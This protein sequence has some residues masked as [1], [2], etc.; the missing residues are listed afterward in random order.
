MKRIALI[1][2]DGTLP[3][4]ALCKLEKHHKEQGDQVVWNTLN[5][6]LAYVSL[7]FTFNRN[8]LNYWMNKPNV[9]IGGSGYDF[10]EENDKLK[11]I[12]N[13]T[14]P[15]YIEDINIHKNFGF[16]TR[17][18]FRNCPFCI[19]PLKEGKGRIVGDLWCLWDKIS[20]EIRFFDNNIL[21]FPKHFM[22]LCHEL[23]VNCL[24]ADFNQGLDIRLM[25]DVLAKKLSHVR[26]IDNAKYRFAWD[27][28]EDKKL[29]LKN[30]RKVF[31]YIKPSRIMV[32]VLCGYDTDFRDDYY[33]VR[34]IKKMGC[35]PFVMKYHKRSKL[36]NEFARWNNLFYFRSLSFKGYLK[37]R[38]YDDL[39]H[40]TQKELKLFV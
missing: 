37:A 30:L 34:K 5:Y 31:K 26:L 38:K 16:T 24:K 14:L 1:D 12:R 27:S 19:V 22:N 36:L 9:I 13:T 40:Q 10:I 8:K 39:L 4:L 15:K 21:F 35:D 17:G 7:L 32:Y 23:I 18:C 2:L 3:N 33:R 11:Q 28:M 29:V 25:T 6:D 20:K